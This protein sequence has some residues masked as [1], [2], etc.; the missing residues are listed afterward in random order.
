MTGGRLVYQVPADFQSLA[1]RADFPNARLPDGKLIRPQALVIPLMGTAPAPTSVQSLWNVSDDTLLVSIGGQTTVDQFAGEQAAA[2]RTYLVLEVDVFNQG[3]KP[4]FFQTDKQLSTIAPDGGQSAP[5]PLTYRGML[6]PTE[7]VWV[8]NGEHR[9]FQVV[10]EVQAGATEHALSYRG[11]TLEQHFSLNSSGVTELSTETAEG[12]VVTPK[13]QEPQITTVQAAD[14]ELSHE[15]GVDDEGEKPSDAPTV[16]ESVEQPLVKPAPKPRI[17]LAAYKEFT[18]DAA[19]EKTL[20]FNDAEIAQLRQ[21]AFLSLEQIGFQDFANRF[22]S[23]KTVDSLES[24]IS[25]EFGK[26]VETI[27]GEEKEVEFTISVDRS[28]AKRGRVQVW[29]SAPVSG[30][31]DEIQ[32]YAYVSDAEERYPTVVSDG[33]TLSICDLQLPEGEHTIRVVHSEDAE[34]PIHIV[35][36]AE[37]NIDTRECENNSPEGFE[38]PVKTNT[39]LSGRMMPADDSD[40]FRWNVTEA[41]SQRKWSIFLLTDPKGSGASLRLLK[42]E[43]LELQFA[44]AK[45][46]EAIT[47]VDLSPPAGDYLLRIAP[48][49]RDKACAY[50]LLV[51]DCGP[52]Q[53]G[54]EREP[55]DECQPAVLP[56]FH[57]GKTEVTT[58][59]GQFFGE[60]TDYFV[61]DI[62]EPDLVYTL[63]LH[64]D[65]ARRISL[66]DSERK[67]LRDCQMNKNLKPALV[68]LSLPL[69][70]NIFAV[71]G[72]SC[73]YVV[74]IEAR[75]A[76]GPYVEREP[77]DTHLRAHRIEQSADY[78]GR[79]LDTYDDDCFRFVVQQAMDYR[80][81]IQAPDGETLKYRLEEDQNYLLG[82]TTRDASLP[83]TIRLYPGNHFIELSTD[84]PFYEPYTIRVEPMHPAGVSS[85]T[86]LL[87]SGTDVGN[88]IVAAA[89]LDPYQQFDIPLTLKN[90][91]DA[92][93]KLQVAGW[94]SNYQVSLEAPET[95]FTLAPKQE[96][97]LHVR[98]FIESDA[99]SDGP[100]TLF[101]AARSI[102]QEQQTLGTWQG[103]LILD[104][105]GAALSA[106]VGKGRI[107]SSLA[108]GL[109]VAAMD[110]GAVP[111]GEN[112]NSVEELLDNV[113]SHRV[114]DGKTAVVKL[115]GDG[116][117]PLVGASFDLHGISRMM[118]GLKD[119]SIEISDDGQV[120]HEIARGQ[121]SAR[122]GNQD[123][124]FANEVK[125]RYAR[126][127]LHGT[128]ADDGDSSDE[129]EL[130]EWRMI[131]KPG[132]SLPEFP[133]M[134]LLRESWGGHEIWRSESAVVYGFHHDRAGR[135]GAFEWRNYR[136]SHDN[137]K[138]PHQI[139][140]SV[141]VSSPAGP[142]QEIGVVDVSA[143]DTDENLKQ[144]V[145]LKDAPWARFVKLTWLEG[146]FPL[147][148][149]HLLPGIFEYH[150]EPS[151]RSL[152]G[153]WGGPVQ[154]A[155]YELKFPKEIRSS[156]QRI[157]ASS[158]KPAN[159]A[160]NVWTESTVWINEDWEDWFTIE[161]PAGKQRKSIEV[162][163]DPFVRV[164]LEATDASGK[165][166]TLV[167]RTTAPG[168]RSWALPMGAEGSYR[169]HVYEPMRSVVFI[170]DMSGSMSNFLD[171]I[172]S[173]V[174]HFA[175]EVNP[176]TERV[177]LLPL[178]E[179]PTP[180]LKQWESNPYVLSDTVRNFD[181]PSSSYAHLNLLEASNMLA[182]EPGTRAAIM[183][184]D[185]ETSRE[186][187]PLLWQSLQEVQPIVYT[188][189]TTDVTR[190]F[191]VEQ[192]DMQDWAAVGGGRYYLI[193]DPYQLD[194]AFG[195]L[196][197]QLRRPAGYRIRTTEERLK[198]ASIELLDNRQP[199]SIEDP[200]D[201]GF[202]L[203]LDMSAS[204]R[205][206]MPDGVTLRSQAA[207]EGLT[208]IIEQLPE[209]T[210]LGIR[211]FGQRGGADCASTLLMPVA[212]LD[213]AKTI[214]ALRSIR[215]SSLGNTAIAEALERAPEDLAEVSGKR[216][217]IIL[218]DGE[219]TC[220]G[221]PEAAIANL[222]QENGETKVSIAGFMLEDPAV[223]QKYQNW[224]G[225]TGGAYYPAADS[226]SLEK[227][228][229][230]AMTAAPA[231]MFEILDS[232]GKVVASGQVGNGSI[233]LES[234]FYRIRTEDGDT[235]R[236]GLIEAIEKDIRLEFYPSSSKP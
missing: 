136:K 92:E 234:G 224:I 105:N 117:V 2:G 160:P 227:V 111:Q 3:D 94:T 87:S 126:L 218:T 145:A 28:L 86:V 154:E 68:D 90:S 49:A 58:V 89:Y 191:G 184:A 61:L 16:F 219:E 173:A 93:Q 142:W 60:E 208:R 212:P 157:D 134:D 113:L 167:P 132:V 159:L 24:P 153:E 107:H 115:A 166:V 226:G 85:Q 214:E 183:I 125:A 144:R 151:Y 101:L 143:A 35:A 197:S 147:P 19:Y 70:K 5:D 59:K 172:A 138:N 123:I 131:A 204:M 77:N 23:L 179:P 225:A 168:K 97:T 78:Q 163:G 217:I 148:E 221:D 135:I 193:Q 199:E 88:P 128:Q 210:Q 122:P 118:N 201:N 228:L 91:S 1:L 216:H 205:T 109:N 30:T 137:R 186:V 17:Q 100:V 12:K 65:R 129:P 41:D 196:Q 72:K 162:E 104:P 76:P 223:Q 175:Q 150:G 165:P 235:T 52:A 229:R 31:K 146:E 213:K 56:V 73:D 43:N 211:V 45:A 200:F 57:P 39:A 47:F 29:V 116:Q 187:N 222:I 170:W 152:L 9:R 189:H 38:N 192:D 215:V 203:I 33:T 133:E 209:G 34:V 20:Q 156:W 15:Q 11:F 185:C 79:L 124:C 48:E 21:Q 4:E 53:P 190:S 182:K 108:G 103:Q 114:F 71:T 164:A 127:L 140:L 231:P 42:H 106:A 178:D 32:L 46:G 63:S 27:I 75:A 83:D 8:P 158:G 98:G 177:Q 236:F 10:F 36:I 18:P 26:P 74:G 207:M 180:L 120:F 55:N 102:G 206:P 195:K 6:H 51:R 66:V 84:K 141:S 82:G 99:A 112:A 155:G 230:N 50:Q 176:K 95:V 69:G 110:L 233:E 171:G 220:R 188:F 64:G 139:Q 181:P 149:N 121:L 174:V 80:I 40:V 96:R 13:I 169:I 198:K 44:R 232:E 37:A 81:T 161:A 119:Y 194:H 25:L 22:G 14:P 7:N 67:T 54:W 130:G 202:L 62:T